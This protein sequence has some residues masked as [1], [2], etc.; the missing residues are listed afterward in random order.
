[1]ENPEKQREKHLKWSR[2]IAKYSTYSGK[3][4]VEESPILMGDNELWC[5]CTYCGKYH[6]IINL[7]AKNRV[8]SLEGKEGG[9]NRLYCSDE[10]KNL[11]PIFHQNKY[12]KGF[13]NYNDGSRCNQA[14]VRQILLDIQFDEL[15]FN[16]CDQCGEIF[17][18]EELYFHHN[19]PIGDEPNEYDNASHYMLKCFKHHDH[20]GC[21]GNK[22]D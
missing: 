2:S 7:Y 15:G 20:R 12:P 3:L 11:C 16:W 6:P 4:T 19:L 17:K 13:K 10:C 1:M 18:P 14:R 8:T 22:Y 5:K 9:E 21:L